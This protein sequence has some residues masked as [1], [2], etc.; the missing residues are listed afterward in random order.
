M[1]NR[2]F[3]KPNL[4]ERPFDIWD[5]K[6]I[7][8]TIPD[9]SRDLIPEKSTMDEASMDQLNAIDYK[10]GCYI[11]QELTARMH[12]RGLGKRKLETI[13]LDTIPDGAALR[14]SCG[15]IGMALVKNS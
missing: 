7:I 11:G 5:H 2:S 15:D 13:K 8:L 6:R 14:S 4:D 3:E 12:Y 9:G 10:K 1:G